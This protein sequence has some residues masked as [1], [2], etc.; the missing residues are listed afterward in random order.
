META[1]AIDQHS[2]RLG[3][4]H[5]VWEVLTALWDAL[6]WVVKAVGTYKMLASGFKWFKGKINGPRKRKDV[7]VALTGV[8]AATAVGNLSPEILIVPA[9]AQS[10][11]AEIANQIVARQQNRR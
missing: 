5:E 9:A 6:Q 8:A 7:V 4:V 10:L 11:N 2:R 3:F 1:V